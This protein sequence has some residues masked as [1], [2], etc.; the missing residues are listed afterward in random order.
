MKQIYFT[1]LAIVLSGCGPFTKA[2]SA[3]SSPDKIGEAK[4][5]N[6]TYL[7]TISWDPA[8]LKGGNS[9]NNTA[10][11]VVQGPTNVSLTGDVQLTAFHPE[12]PAMGHGTNEADQVI[13]PKVGE[14][15]HFVVSGVHFSMAG[16]EG[17]WVVAM[18]VS[19]NGTPDVA[20]VPLPVVE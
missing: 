14:V 3:G 6:G 8:Q 18:T 17:E 5:E 1:M 4:S 10:L 11:V 16:S 2:K 19:I 13:T 20:K 9:V 15:G 12:M 7:A